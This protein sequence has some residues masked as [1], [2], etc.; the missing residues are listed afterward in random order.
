MDMKAQISAVAESASI[1]TYGQSEADATGRN[2]AQRSSWRADHNFSGDQNAKKTRI[3][4]GVNGASASKNA[5]LTAW[6]H[7]RYKLHK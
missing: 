5:E 6:L 3:V 2:T 4:T 1:E 7:G